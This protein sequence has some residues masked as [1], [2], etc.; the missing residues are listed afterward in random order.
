[1]NFTKFLNTLNNI[2]VK[3]SIRILNKEIE[4]D[5]DKPNVFMAHRW[6]S[7]SEPQLQSI[8]ETQ[9]ASNKYLT[10]EQQMKMMLHCVEESINFNPSYI[11]KK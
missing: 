9:M 6:I 1:M 7:M 5:T 11:K 10:P 2:V 4:N 8:A 3:K